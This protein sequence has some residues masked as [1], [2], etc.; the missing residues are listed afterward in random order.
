MKDKNEQTPFSICLSTDNSPILKLLMNKVSLNKDH[1][2]FFS[3][4]NRIFNVEYQ[5]I[6]L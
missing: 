6:L 3:F 4:A 5:K 1:D 2:L